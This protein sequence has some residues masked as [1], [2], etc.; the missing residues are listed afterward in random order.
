[1]G[2]ELT[3]IYLKHDI[4]YIVRAKSNYVYKIEKQH[5]KSAFFEYTRRRYVN[6]NPVITKTTWVI[7]IFEEQEKIKKESYYTNLKVTRRNI[8]QFHIQYD[9]RWNIEIDY[10]TN[11]NFMPRTCSKKYVIRAFYFFLCVIMRNVLT[12]MNLQLKQKDNC[13]YCSKPIISSYDFAF[14]IA[15]ASF[16]EE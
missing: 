9:K 13:W 4:I 15:M 14:L 12:F 2:A 16:F 3:D 6:K 8:D 10:R 5:E 1:M 11:N 7:N